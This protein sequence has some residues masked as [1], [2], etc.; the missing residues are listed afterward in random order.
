MT[1]NRILRMSSTLSIP[2][3]FRAL[4]EWASGLPCRHSWR[5]SLNTWDQ[6]RRMSAGLPTWQAGGPLHRAGDK[7]KSPRWFSF[8]N[9]CLCALRERGR[10]FFPDVG[11]GGERV[12]P[13]L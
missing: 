1:A 11:D 2:L 3:R 10:D 13:R 4:V 7:T 12:V 8:A 6:Q 5:H 9:D